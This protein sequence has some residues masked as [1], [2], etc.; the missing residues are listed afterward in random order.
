EGHAAAQF[1]T[2]R[3][4]R[5]SETLSREDLSFIE[6]SSLLIFCREDGVLFGNR[7]WN[8]ERRVVPKDGSLAR[9]RVVFGYLVSEAGSV[10]EGGETVAEAGR[11][12]EHDSVFF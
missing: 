10:S 12:P 3:L 1:P 7:P 5:E 2:A 8:G 11:N 4:R 9:W 6:A